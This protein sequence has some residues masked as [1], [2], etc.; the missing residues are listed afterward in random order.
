MRTTSLVIA[1]A[2]LFVGTLALSSTRAEEYSP[3]VQARITAVENGLIPAVR[4][5][6]R[7]TPCS[8][9][10][11]LDRDHVPGVTVAVI[12][13]YQIEWAKG[14][15]VADLETGRPVTSET[16]F[17]AASMSKPVTA[18]AAL[19]LVER[20]ELDLDRDVNEQ[21]K[22]W[23]VPKNEFSRQHAVDLRGLLSHTAGCG[24]H[25]CG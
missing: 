3:A 12:N 22:S 16:L 9:A 5:K 14:Y 24:R 2:S 17:Q 4:I 23:H 18:L 19:K 25:V 7:T 20:G 13:D 11:R 1:S 6:G 15:G 8:I 10:E 21:L